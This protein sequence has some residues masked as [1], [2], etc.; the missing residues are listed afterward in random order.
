LSALETLLA[1]L[2]AKGSKQRDKAP[3][4]KRQSARSAGPVGG[5]EGRDAR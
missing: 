1:A 2:T 5:H 3:A 4:A